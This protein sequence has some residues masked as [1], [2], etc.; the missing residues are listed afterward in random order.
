MLPP[1]IPIRFFRP[2]TLDMIHVDRVGQGNAPLLDTTNMLLYLTEDSALYCLDV[3]A[4]PKLIWKHKDE[5][6]FFR[7]TP[8]LY[9]TLL[10]AMTHFNLSV[11]HALTGQ[12]LWTFYPDEPFAYNYPPEVSN[13]YIYA[14]SPDR[15]YAI[16]INTH[17][18]VWKMNSDGG[19]VSV[20]NGCLFVSTH[21]GRLYCYGSPPTDVTDDTRPDL[22]IDY[23]LEQNYPNPFNP[24]TEISFSLSQRNDIELEVFDPTGRLV[25]TLA[26]GSYPPGDFTV[27]WNGKDHA[28]G[29]YLY[30]LTAGDRVESKKMVLVK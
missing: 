23:M 7:V 18:A 27:E 29:V 2:D 6:I 20:G 28:S 16:D 25:E 15:V 21:E 12:L 24:T 10:I 22:P 17:Q 11:Y 19:F 9:D 30:R 14:S 8:A 4:D 13:G 5:G 1:A 3:S 26:E